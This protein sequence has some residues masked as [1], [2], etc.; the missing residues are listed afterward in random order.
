MNQIELATLEEV[1]KDDETP[2]QDDQVAGLVAVANAG[3]ADAQRD[4]A[5]WLADRLTFDSIPV[6]IKTL[7]LIVDLN[8]KG[9]H[10]STCHHALCTL[11]PSDE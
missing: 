7:K 1:T 2:A 4:M 11:P 9:A 5:K 10:S 8:A 6:K 3:S